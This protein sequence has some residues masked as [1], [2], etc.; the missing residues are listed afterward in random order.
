MNDSQRIW[1]V[2]IFM[3]FFLMFLQL[4]E[5]F[6]GVLAIFFTFL[7]HVNLFYINFAPNSSSFSVLFADVFFSDI[8][9]DDLRFENFEN[10]DFLC[11]CRLTEPGLPVFQ[12]SFWNILN[13][14]DF[15]MILR[16]SLLFSQCFFYTNLYFMGH[17]L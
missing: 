11:I 3:E 5:M 9:L 15:V 7:P 17:I 13:Q 8:F 10:L 16:F 14:F 12:S 6:L 2:E 1:D 4:F